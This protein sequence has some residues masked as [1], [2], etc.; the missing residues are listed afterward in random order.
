MVAFLKVKVTVRACIHNR[1]ITISTTEWMIVLQPN[2]FAHWKYW[3][4]VVKVSAK[5]Q[6]RSQ[7]SFN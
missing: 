7:L 4:A 5:F 2:I 6:L 3:I 1:N